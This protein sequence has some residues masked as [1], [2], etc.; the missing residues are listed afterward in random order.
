[1]SATK[2]VTLSN[3]PDGIEVSSNLSYTVDGVA[4]QKTLKISKPS[5]FADDFKL[6]AEVSKAEAANWTVNKVFTAIE[7]GDDEFQRIGVCAT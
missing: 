6:E 2:N 3:I 1:M 4:L 5:D 7:A